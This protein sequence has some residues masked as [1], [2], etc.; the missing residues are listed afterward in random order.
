LPYKQILSFKQVS[1]KNNPIINRWKSNFIAVILKKKVNNEVLQQR[2]KR[3]SSL[4]YSILVIA[5]LFFIL[6]LLK[7]TSNKTR[8]FS[9]FLYYCKRFFSPLFY[10]GEKNGEVRYFILYLLLQNYFLLKYTS[11]KTSFSSIFLR[12]SN[13]FDNM[14]YFIRI[15]FYYFHLFLAD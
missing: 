4:F 5:K 14:Y 13:M 3:R 8:I 15:F 9:F 1:R 10:N 2:T 11:N 6:M 12:V 7:Y